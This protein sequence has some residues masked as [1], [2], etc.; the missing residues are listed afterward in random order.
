[1]TEKVE[2]NGPNAHPLYVYLRSHSELYD[3]KTKT[4]RVIPWNFSKFIVDHNGEVIKFFP[5]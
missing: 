3:E 1:L 5:P 2:I 4:S